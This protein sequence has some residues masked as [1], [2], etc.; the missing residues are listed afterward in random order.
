MQ[1]KLGVQ[2]V[3]SAEMVKEELEDCIKMA[4]YKKMKKEMEKYENLKE[5]KNGDLRDKQ[6]YMK[7]KS[8]MAFRICTRMVK[9]VK[10]NL[11]NM[12]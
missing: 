12:K 10:I 4:N 6:D 1:D 3:N 11:T 2:D 9:K 8:R 5:I 7:E